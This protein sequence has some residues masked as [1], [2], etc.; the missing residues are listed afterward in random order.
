MA[1]LEQTSAAIAQVTQEQQEVTIEA[2][3]RTQNND[4]MISKDYVLFFTLE[5]L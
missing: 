4:I 1:S 3:V 2:Q 5:Q